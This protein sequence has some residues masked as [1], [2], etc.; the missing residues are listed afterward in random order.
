MLTLKELV[1]NGKKVHFVLYRKGHL[2]YK[3]DDGFE[4]TVPIEDCGDGVFLAEDKAILFMRYIRKQLAA[5]AEG[6]SDDL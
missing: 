6:Q 5:N 1:A 3:T 4:F 2:H